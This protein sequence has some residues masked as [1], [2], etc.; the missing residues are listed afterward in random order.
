MSGTA[1]SEN[2]L[3]DQ[4]YGATS[5]V[6][7]IPTYWYI[8]LSTTTPTEA[9]ANVTEPSSGSYARIPV[10]NDKVSFTTATSG[11]LVNDI[12]FTF[13]ESTVSWGTVT[14]IVYYD[15]L[16]SGNLWYFEALPSP[17]A[18]AANT[19]VYFS[20]GTLFITTRN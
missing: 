19:T 2:K 1:Y 13:N 14:H 8:G 17:R 12:V 6:S 9:G 7:S 15:A 10:A 4:L 11:S 3:L 5:I 18:I 20:S 16:T